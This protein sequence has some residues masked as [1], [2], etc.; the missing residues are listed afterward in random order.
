MCIDKLAMSLEKRWIA[1]HRL[2]QQVSRLQQHLPMGG[3]VGDGK[4]QCLSVTIKVE[5]YQVDRWGL[6][7]YRFFTRRKF[8]LKC[9]GDGFGDLALNSKDVRQITIIGVR[10]DVSIVAG[11][12]QLGV[13]PHLTTGALHAAF[14]EVVNPERLADS[15]GIA[16]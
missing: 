9:I 3:G 11:I 1:R 7:D 16:A 10:P 2:G 13:D 8:G 12:D 4:I 14:D 6:L 5:S 15:A